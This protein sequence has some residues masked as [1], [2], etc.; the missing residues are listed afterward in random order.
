MQKRNNALQRPDFVGLP[1]CWENAR[2]SSWVDPEIHVG[3]PYIDH[4]AAVAKVSARLRLA[5]SRIGTRKPA[6]IDAHA[7]ADRNNRSKLQAIVDKAPRAPWQASADAHAAQLVGYLQGALAEAFPKPKQRKRRSYL[8]DDTW[9]LYAQVAALRHRCARLRAHT[10]YHLLA[11]A[12]RAWATRGVDDFESALASPWAL[13]ASFQGH[14]HR[15]ALRG[16]S[17]QLKH[18]CRTDRAR[19]LSGLADEVQANTPGSYQALNRLLSH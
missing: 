16:L 19:H 9:A 2:V 3:Q 6:S 5:G 4:F 15:D 10:Q 12:F 18:A 7:L 14:R 17:K 13:E 1:D 8:T 11:A